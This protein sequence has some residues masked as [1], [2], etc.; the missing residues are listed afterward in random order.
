MNN[1]IKKIVESKYNFNIDTENNE[2]GNSLSKSNVNTKLTQINAYTQQLYTDLDLPSGTLWA[3]Y[4][5]GVKPPLGNDS[6]FSDWYGNYYAWGEI[7][8]NK[9]E[10][11]SWD[12]Y[13]HCLGKQN[14]MIKYTTDE[15]S[16]KYIDN[17]M[18]LQLKDDAA[19]QLTKNN[20]IQYVIP[21]A[22]QF[23]ELIKNTNYEWKENYND[24]RNLTGVLFTSKI[25]QDKSIFIPAAG[26]CQNLLSLASKTIGSYWTSDVL[27]TESC[28]ALTL[29]ILSDRVMILY[30][31]RFYGQSIRPV[32]KSNNQNN[33]MKNN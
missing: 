25:N 32:V 16:S 15:R 18:E 5:L 7:I 9:P 3:N 6:Y 33:D 21:K 8:P 20:D 12:T 4:N 26:Y 13:K 2:Y 28:N 23:N 24:I 11:F 31:N 17:I 19:Y 22:Q 27:G 10:G 30:G 14:S 1:L 29:N